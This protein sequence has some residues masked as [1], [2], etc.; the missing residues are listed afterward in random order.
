MS[1]DDYSTDILIRTNTI[2]LLYFVWHPYRSVAH[3]DSYGVY[4][5]NF[6]NQL[7]HE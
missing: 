2:V 1:V 5:W 3:A 7:V 4:C 6:S